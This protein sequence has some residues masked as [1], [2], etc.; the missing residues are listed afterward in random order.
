MP[1]GKPKMPTMD[2]NKLVQEQ[3]EETK[4]EQEYVK[5]WMEKEGIKFGDKFY[6]ICNEKLSS[7]T[8]G[9]DFFIDMNSV[10]EGS[11]CGDPSAGCLKED[12]ESGRIKKATQEE[13]VE[14][15]RSEV[16]L[17]EKKVKFA[18]KHL[19]YTKEELA[20]EESKL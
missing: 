4:Q 16:D 6:I 3:K 11:E 17:C 8:I 14:H 18:E 13:V 5:N 10:E 12:L 1:I 20:L 15:Y 7:M 2:D 19:L 9:E